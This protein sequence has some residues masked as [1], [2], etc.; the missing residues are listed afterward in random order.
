ML[1]A[2]FLGHSCVHVT[3]G[4]HK[5]IIDPFL[6]NN[7][8]ATI[9]AD[10]VDVDYILVT[11]GHSDHLGDAVAISKRTDATIIAANELA[12]YV[13]KQGALAHNMHIGGAYNFEFGR[14]KLTIAH[15]GSGA[16]ESGLEYTGSPCG[17]IITMGGKTI[18]HTGDTGLFY[19]MKLIG[20]MNPVDIMFLPIGDNFTMGVDDAAKAVELVNPKIVAPMHYG[21]WDIIDTDPEDF[22][23]RLRGRSVK[24]AVLKPN[25]TIEI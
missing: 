22:K 15:H 11:H 8:Q 6:T 12:L 5:I 2:T 16:G 23:I 3:D 10:E 19:D 24:V 9:K 14:V 25:Q 20:E 21:T 18:Y 7:P 13:S 17:F 4:K 1:K